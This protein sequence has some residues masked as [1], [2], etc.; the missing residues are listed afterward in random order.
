M[1]LAIKQKLKKE[2]GS[3]VTFSADTGTHSCWV[4]LLIQTLGKKIYFCIFLHTYCL[5]RI[6]QNNL[7]LFC[8]AVSN[9]LH[10][11]AQSLLKVKKDCTYTC[12]VELVFVLRDELPKVILCC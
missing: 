6:E 4:S 1:L 7:T 10:F 11:C 8:N 2:C 5:A 3:E 12:T 9:Y